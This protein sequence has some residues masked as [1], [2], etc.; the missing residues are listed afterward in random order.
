MNAEEKYQ[1][2]KFAEY[3]LARYYRGNKKDLA[4]AITE[5]RSGN[6]NS[7]EFLEQFFQ[8]RNEDKETI[9]RKIAEWKKEF[10]RKRS[11]GKISRKAIIPVL[12]ILVLAAGYFTWKYV[13]GAND[14]SQN[15]NPDR[16]YV[17]TTSGFRAHATPASKGGYR[18]YFKYGDTVTNLHDTLNGWL[19][20][21]QQE[22]TLYGPSKYFVTEDV[23]LKHDSLFKDFHYN[24]SY[25]TINSKAA[26]CIREF[27]DKSL[28]SSVK[29]WHIPLQ[30]LN[31]KPARHAV[32]SVPRAVDY[33]KVTGEGELEKY[34]LLLVSRRN[35]RSADSV[36]HYALLLELLPNGS[37]IKKE[38]FP[39]SIADAS[40][41]ITVDNVDKYL[42]G[43]INNN[44]YLRTETKKILRLNWSKGMEAPKWEWIE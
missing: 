24:T 7:I 3:C 33:V 12:A 23:F 26:F 16:L 5:L 32:L 30:S 4:L 20:F 17:I 8:R 39:L 22:K 11:F 21:S 31:I 38:D 1:G 15:K 9:D 27:I 29:E 6:K 10:E 40:C 28:H 13:A 18:R 35:V 36:N 44:V 2:T 34:H 25:E 14:H 43:I 37:V 19:K 41:Y 42:R